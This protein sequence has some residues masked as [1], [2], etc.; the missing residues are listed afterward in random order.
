MN[1]FIKVAINEAEDGIK[2]NDGGP[3]GAV[4]TRRGKIISKEHNRVIKNNDPTA[5][6]EILAIREAAGE[7]KSFDLSDCEIYSTCE[8]CPMCLGAIY[9]AK[10]KKIYFG[11][12]RK[13][14]STIGFMDDFIYKAIEGKNKNK[15]VKKIKINGKECRELFCGWKD[16][17]DKTPY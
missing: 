10:I 11:C 6:A 1:P 2:K 5:H 13:D 16:K 9:W 14:A 3:F 8:P 12:T 15:I 7:L 4:I 17:N